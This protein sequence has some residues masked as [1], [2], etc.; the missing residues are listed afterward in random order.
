MSTGCSKPLRLL[1]EEKSSPF[2]HL[3]GALPALLKNIGEFSRLVR[4]RAEPC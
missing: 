2:D 1:S 4:I 3:T